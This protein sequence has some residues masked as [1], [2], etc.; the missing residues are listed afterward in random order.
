MRKTINC[1]TSTSGW[2]VQIGSY[3]SHER[4]AAVDGT[5]WDS[6]STAW[7]PKPPERNVY[8]EMSD[9]EMEVDRDELFEI[10][11]EIGDG[12]PR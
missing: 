7:I 6:V 9:D 1:T 5:V 2:Y 10:A 8:F 4:I 11:C 3:G 12:K